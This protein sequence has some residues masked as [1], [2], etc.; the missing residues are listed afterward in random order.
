M[1]QIIDREYRVRL[2]WNRHDVWGNELD[3]WNDICAWAIETFGLPG[4]RF[5]TKAT[6]DY[7]DFYFQDEKDAIYFSL[8]WL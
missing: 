1:V 7:M 6:E 2:L 4:H 8:R 3:K 5:S